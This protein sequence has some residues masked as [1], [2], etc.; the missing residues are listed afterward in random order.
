VIDLLNTKL[1]LIKKIEE[2]TFNILEIPLEDEE[3]ENSLNKYNELID[4]RQNLMNEIDD[5]DY[6]INSIDLQLISFNSDFTKSKDLLETNIKFIL[7]NIIDMD[8]KIKLNTEKELILT[9][10]KINEAEQ[11]LQTSD[12]ELNKEDKKPIGYYLNKKS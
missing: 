6:K 1:E 12:F 9:K 11:R 3:F 5:I 2:L 10:R 4:K 7:K 8:K